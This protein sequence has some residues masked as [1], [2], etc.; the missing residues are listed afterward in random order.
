MMGSSCWA[1]AALMAATPSGSYRNSSFPQL[2][3]PCK[4]ASF[5]TPSSGTLQL[6]LQAHTSAFLNVGTF[7][8]ANKAAL[9][10]FADLIDPLIC[11]PLSEIVCPVARWRP[12]SPSRTCKLAGSFQLSV[13]KKVTSPTVLYFHAHHW[14]GCSSARSVVLST[15]GLVPRVK[16]NLPACKG[17]CRLQ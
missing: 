17:S 11:R 4:Y 16:L 13:S 10:P 8:L 2:P 6:P 7:L 3:F 1:R 5:S 15:A 9:Q 12:S 14:L